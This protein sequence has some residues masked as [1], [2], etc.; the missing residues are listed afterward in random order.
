[1]FCSRINCRPENSQDNWWNDESNPYSG[2]AGQGGAGQHGGTYDV[3]APGRNTYHGPARHYRTPLS[4]LTGPS[5]QFD[6]SPTNPTGGGIAATAKINPTPL[7]FMDSSA[8]PPTNSQQPTRRKSSNTS[9]DK[10]VQSQGHQYQSPMAALFSNPGY[11]QG[12]D[13]GSSGSSSSGGG[14]RSR[15]VDRQV[16][17]R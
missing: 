13:V 1:M 15:F 2:S 14:G 10:L 17:F 12:Q 3:R 16:H 9:V 4:A 8:L 5:G 6:T 7:R 11:P